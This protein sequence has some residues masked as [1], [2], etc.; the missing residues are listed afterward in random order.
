[1]PL[2]II[3]NDI[4]KVQADAI[5]NTANPHPVIGRGTDSAVYEAAG[6]EL[7]LE[8]RKKIGDIAEGNAA[9]TPA[10][11]LNAKYI[12]HTVSPIWYDGNHL[13]TYLLSS[14]YRQSLELAAE[15][16]CES[17]AF[18]LL[19]AG[20]NAFP[21]DIALKTALDTI[22]D[23][24]MDHEMDVSLVVLDRSAYELSSRIFHDVAS[25][26]EEHQAA[27]VF[28]REY[29][30]SW[31]EEMEDTQNLLPAA[32]SI[33]RPPE[34]LEKKPQAKAGALPGAKKPR[35]PSVSGWMESIRLPKKEQTFQVRLLKLID[36]SG[37][38]DPQIYKRAN[39][40]RKLFAKIRKDENYRPSRKTVIALA[41]AL[42][43]S[44]DDAVDLLSRAGFA[45][46]PA[47]TFDLIIRYCFE[48]RVYN[49]IEVN[50]IL[51]GFDQETL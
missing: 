33:A 51:F 9:L 42:Q 19:A 46:S 39:I 35:K 7:L 29:A 38:T 17:I 10:F 41:L 3:R 27:K 37:E 22:Q 21:N 23:F 2:K 26:I 34:H 4:T 36:E 15:H 13:E 18:P 44:M 14:C 11:G 25:Y 31:R 5:V 8:E 6:R 16:G 45:L 43:L 28:E 48:N 32:P 24:L 49:I 50:S 40:D 30:S 1:M 12:I 20:S 47:S